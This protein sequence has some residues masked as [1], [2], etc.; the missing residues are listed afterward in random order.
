MIPR[1]SGWARV[2]CPIRDH[3][4]SQLSQTSALH[5][6]CGEPLRIAP[7]H[8]AIRATP[9]EFQG[10]VL[11]VEVCPIYRQAYQVRNLWHLSS[12]QL[13]LTDLK[14]PLQCFGW[15]PTCGSSTQVLDLSQEQYWEPGNVYKAL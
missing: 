7:S 2:C 10:L 4:I 5:T 11:G 8:L 1:R 9:G 6:E 3:S 14:K 15:L 13:P 12:I